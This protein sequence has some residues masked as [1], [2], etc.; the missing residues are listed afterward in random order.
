M[1]CSSVQE[2]S[3]ITA[4]LMLM[5]PVCLRFYSLHS[6]YA[7]SRAA[8]VLA[9]SASTPASVLSG[10]V[11]FASEQVDSRLACC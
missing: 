5:S 3:G 1:G 2:H 10:Q 11:C 7:L 4:S 6:S 8:D 9:G